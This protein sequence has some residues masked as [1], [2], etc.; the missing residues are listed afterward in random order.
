M[1]TVSEPSAGT[2][3]LTSMNNLALAL[4]KAG[5]RTE[6]AEMHRATLLV[7]RRVLGDDHPHTL[8]PS[9]RHLN[10]RPN[11]HRNYHVVGTTAST[12]QTASGTALQP[13]TCDGGAARY[14]A[15]AAL[16]HAGPSR[17]I[18]RGS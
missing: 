7:Q 1:A 6:A 3:A 11:Y 18:P 2:K 16:R 14:T 15:A 17:S 5:K 9:P 4:S 13:N 12:A 8:T 10:Y